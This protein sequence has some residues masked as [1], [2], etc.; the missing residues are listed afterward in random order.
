MKR[1]SSQPSRSWTQA[2]HEAGFSDSAHLT[3]TFKRMFGLNPAALVQ[4]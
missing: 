4:V 1:S 2:A 3:R